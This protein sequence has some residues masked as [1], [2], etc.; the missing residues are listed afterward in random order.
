ME[1]YAGSATPHISTDK[2]EAYCGL[3]AFISAPRFRDYVN[4]ADTLR[5]ASL[6]DA[7]W[8]ERLF[9]DVAGLL[10]QQNAKCPIG[11]KASNMLQ[12]CCP[13]RFSKLKGEMEAPPAETTTRGHGGP[14]ARAPL[15][16]SW[17]T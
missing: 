14:G 9:Y 12:G 1:R 7:I 15:P 2:Q 11:C 13:N 10:F 16:Q 17:Q 4:Q 8:V 6:Q 3:H 5:L